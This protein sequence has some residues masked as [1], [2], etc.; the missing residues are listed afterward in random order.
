MK[1]KV[2]I[3]GAITDDLFSR[4]RFRPRPRFFPYYCCYC[5]IAV[6]S[7]CRLLLVF[8]FELGRPFCHF[9]WLLRSFRSCTSHVI[10]VLVSATAAITAVRPAEKWQPT[11]DGR[12]SNAACT[13]HIA[14][15]DGNPI[16]EA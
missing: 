16:A 9:G 5:F 10:P 7:V 14:L 6:G 13:V 15:R 8:Y 11:D 4:R 3:K 1:M 2:S 12:S